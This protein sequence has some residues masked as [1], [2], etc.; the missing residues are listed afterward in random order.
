M[1]DGLSE[2][3]TGVVGIHDFYMDLNIEGGGQ[4]QIHLSLQRGLIQRDTLRRSGRQNALAHDSH[5]RRGNMLQ[6]PADSHAD[7]VLNVLPAALAAIHHTA[8]F[9]QLPL[10]EIVMQRLVHG[11]A[12]VADLSHIGFFRPHMVLEVVV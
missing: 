8:V 5:V 3:F 12:C 4:G 9:F 2:G 6:K 1:V 10:A 11:I 7:E